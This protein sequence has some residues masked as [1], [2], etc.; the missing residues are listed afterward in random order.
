MTPDDVQL[1][2][3]SPSIRRQFLDIQLAQVDPLYVH[4]LGRYVKAMR[5]RNYLLKQK[6]LASIEVWNMKWPKHPPIL[7]CKDA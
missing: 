2:K 5:Q 6:S 4:Y 7:F 3:G 1:I